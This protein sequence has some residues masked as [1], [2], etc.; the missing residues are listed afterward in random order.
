MLQASKYRR[1]SD[2]GTAMERGKE[3]YVCI[4]QEEKWIVLK[5][6]MLYQK[7]AAEAS[8]YLL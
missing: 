3:V 4:N 2:R 6:R 7:K 8:I 5:S 1:I